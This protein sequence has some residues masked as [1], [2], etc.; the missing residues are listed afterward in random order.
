MTIRLATIDDIPDLSELLNILFSQEVEFIPDEIVEQNGLKK[1]INNPELGFI[2]VAEMNSKIC[3]MVNILYTV[4]TAL[5]TRVALL[6]DMITTVQG[7]GIGSILI[8]EAIKIAKQNGCT[9]VTLLTDNNN[10]KAIK[11][12]EKNGFIKSSMLP[13]RL[14]LT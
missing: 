11:F 2:L 13:M 1:I 10:F 6:E 5:G 14:S 3:A 12:Y 8:Q 7:I 9:R 4:S